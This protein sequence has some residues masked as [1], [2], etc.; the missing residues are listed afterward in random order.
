M[1]KV[2][3]EVMTVTCPIEVVPV[4]LNTNVELLDPVTAE[5]VVEFVLLIEEFAVTVTAPIVVLLLT[6]RIPPLSV[7]P[8]PPILLM[9]PIERI[10][11]LMI[12]P[13]L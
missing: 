4:V 2:S 8:P 13:P 9:D 3:P 10:P 12:V 7:S 11:C 6:S 5:R 1:V